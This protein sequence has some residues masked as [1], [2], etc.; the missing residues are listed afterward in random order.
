MLRIHHYFPLGS[1]NIGDLLVARAIRAAIERHFGPCEFVDMPVNDRYRADDRTVGLRGENLA[2]SNAEADLVI[3][4]GSNLLEPRKPAHQRGVGQPMWGVFTS[5][6]AIH[7]LRPPLVLLGM[8]TGSSFGKRIRRYQ[9]QAREEVCLL[10]ERSIAAAVR[11]VTTVRHLARIGVAAECTGCPVTFLTDR[12]VTAQ[13]ASAPLLVSFPPSRILRHWAGRRFMCD[14]MQYIQQLHRAGVPLVIT[15]HETRDVETARQWAPS[16]IPVFYTEDVDE[17]IARYEECIGVIGFR[18][19]AALL[20]LGLGKPVVPVG[21]DWRGLSFIETFGVAD[22]SIRPFRF[23]QFGK[24]QSLTERLLQHD[25]TLIDRLD[26]QK[27][28]FRSRYESFLSVA[29]AEFARISSN[30]RS[31]RAA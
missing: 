30:G 31:T 29:A 12:P 20:G 19:H 18:L 10:H 24:L 5:A 23:G 9:P 27:A 22:I 11:D 21:V 2:R 16:G 28:A 25:Q 6:E 3:V 7:N 26:R 8:G 1:D 13:A 4:G 15:L 14:S 17:L